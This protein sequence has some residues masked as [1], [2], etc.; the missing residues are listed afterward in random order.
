MISRD[1]LTEKQKRVVV[2][3]LSSAFVYLVFKYILPIIFPFI[4]SLLLALAFEPAAKKINDKMR[5]PKSFTAFVLQILLGAVISILFFYVVKKLLEQAGN[6]VSSL[7]E[8]EKSL[9]EGLMRISGYAEQWLHMEKSQVFERLLELLMEGSRGLQERIVPFFIDNSSR[10]FAGFVGITTILVLIQVAVV[11]CVKELDDI[12][13]LEE[14]SVFLKEINLIK[15]PIVKVGKAYLKT[16]VI[17]LS[18]VIS[19]LIFGLS[20]MGNKYSYILGFL[21]GVLDALPLFGTGTV[22]IPW[23]LIELVM[24]NFVKMFSILFLYL[25]CYFTRQFL[26]PKLMG[27]GSG[28]SSLETLISIYAGLRLF[29]IWGLFTGPIAWLLIKEFTRAYS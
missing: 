16:Q 28:L 21:I 8:Y 24:G 17:I 12:R 23:I 4:L 27:D 29:G 22:L 5:I 13:R 25:V 11:L 10:I 14:N 18:I 2:F 3:L 19:E 7:P 9:Y 1:K 15:R 6:L 20:V 26:E